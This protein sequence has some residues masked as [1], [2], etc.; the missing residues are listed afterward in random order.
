M[1]SSFY[2]GGKVQVPE[3]TDGPTLI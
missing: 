3:R 2:E 1:K